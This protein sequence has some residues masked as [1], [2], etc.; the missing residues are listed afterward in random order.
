MLHSWPVTL[1]STAYST[2]F[3]L[4][5]THRAFDSAIISVPLSRYHALLD[6]F[7]LRQRRE[8][9]LEVLKKCHHWQVAWCQICTLTCLEVSKHISHTRSKKQ[10]EIWRKIGISDR[11]EQ[12]KGFIHISAAQGNGRQLW[13]GWE[14]PRPE[15]PPTSGILREGN[16]DEDIRRGRGDYASA[17]RLGKA[18]LRPALF[19]LFP[20]GTLSP[21]T[22]S[23]FSLDIF[24]PQLLPAAHK[25]L[26]PQIYGLSL[27]VLCYV[28]ALYRKIFFTTENK[29]SPCFDIVPI[30][31]ACSTPSWV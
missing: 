29:L 3:S 31:K 13:N 25:I 18:F 19:S 23:L 17:P 22:R 21:S 15:S 12:M 30:E 5:V 2:I 14:E 20:I 27:C 10:R 26:I 4:R 24:F 28:F 16:R 11:P 1:L 8:D 6:S 9:G 7:D